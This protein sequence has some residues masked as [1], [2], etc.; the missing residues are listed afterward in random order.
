M[1]N[2]VLPLSLIIVC[3][4]VCVWKLPHI[5]RVYTAPPSSWSFQRRG[6]LPSP[7][8]LQTEPGWGLQSGTT[9]SI[10]SNWIGKGL[11]QAASVKRA[12]PAVRTR[13]KGS[14]RSRANTRLAKIPVTLIWWDADLQCTHA[15]SLVLLSVCHM[16]RNYI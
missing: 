9:Y 6:P 11:Q 10:W 16:M 12:P 8:W 5:A 3:V 2:L 7:Q 14:K 1:Q 4:C 15:L 13:T